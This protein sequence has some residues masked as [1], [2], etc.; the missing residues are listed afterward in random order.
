M[1]RKAV[2]LPVLFAVV[3]VPLALFVSSGAGT[4]MS[5]L[6]L[7]PPPTVVAVLPVHTTEQNWVSL[8]GCKITGS[9]FGCWGSRGIASHVAGL[10]YR[11]ITPTPCGAD[12]M[13]HV[14]THAFSCS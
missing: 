5:S 3:V 9:C 13:V 7:Y 1:I 10:K 11:E 4:H 14:R 2:L 12:V 8:L 6:L